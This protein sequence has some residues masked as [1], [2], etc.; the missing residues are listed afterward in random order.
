[1]RREFLRAVMDAGELKFHVA[2]KKIPYAG[3]DGNTVKPT[4]N[5]GIKLEAFIFDVFPLSKNMA[6]L[7]IIREDEFSPVKNAP[8]SKTDSPDTAR[9][10][11]SGQ[12][13]HWLE[14]AGCDFTSHMITAGA[15]KKQCNRSIK[16]WND[17]YLVID[18]YTNKFKFFK[19]ESEYTNGTK[20]SAW[21]TLLSYTICKDNKFECRTSSG[22]NKV[23]RLTSEEDVPKWVQALDDA[24]AAENRANRLCE[25]RFLFTIMLSLFS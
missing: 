7:D 18:T 24:F 3:D 8:G 20:K 19:S 1:M 17:R 23:F 5:S 4:E 9:S 14:N 10:M 15:V 6:V 21:G 13:R 16:R 12:A 22:E 11:L 2:H 25:V